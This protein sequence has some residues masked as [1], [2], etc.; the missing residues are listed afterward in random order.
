[1]NDNPWEYGGEHEDMLF[2]GDG[3]DYAT[4][5]DDPR[6]LPEHLRDAFEE[7]WKRNEVG[8]RYLAHEGDT[9]DELRASLAAAEKR[10]R[11]AD[12]ML[13][14]FADTVVPESTGY[15]VAH[16]CIRCGALTFKGEETLDHTDACLVT[17]ARQWRKE[18]G[19]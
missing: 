14:E 18:A 2:D 1:M 7:S 6:P 16:R 15:P 19:R 4:G 8:Y 17:R 13:K 12:E 9:P 5:G 10:L 11:E 3:E